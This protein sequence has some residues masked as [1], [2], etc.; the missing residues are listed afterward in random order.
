[1]DPDMAN[2]QRLDTQLSETL[3]NLTLT[4]A[5]DSR[6]VAKHDNK[7]KESPVDLRAWCMPWPPPLQ[8]KTVPAL[9]GNLEKLP[10]ELVR[11]LIPE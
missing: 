5:A 4:A 1:M 3:A 7:A 8:G 6:D 9:V 11:N 10:I 2:P